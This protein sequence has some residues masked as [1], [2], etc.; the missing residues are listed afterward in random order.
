MKIIIKVARKRFLPFMGWMLCSFLFVILG[1]ISGACI[2]YLGEAIG[3]VTYPDVMFSRI[4]F[5]IFPFGGGVVGLIALHIVRARSWLKM[6]HKFMNEYKKWTTK[7]TMAIIFI[8]ETAWLIAFTAAAT[9]LIA[10]L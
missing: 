9:V 10:I 4:A 3:L 1:W 5:L 8:D 6:H 2:G 7:Y